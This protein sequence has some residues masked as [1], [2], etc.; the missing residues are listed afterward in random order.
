MFV[1]LTYIDLTAPLTQA[2]GGEREGTETAGGG[3]EERGGGEGKERGR[4]TP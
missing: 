2:D 1:I 3:Q 4:R